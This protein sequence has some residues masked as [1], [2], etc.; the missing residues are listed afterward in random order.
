MSSELP[1]R[2]FL[3]YLTQVKEELAKRMYLSEVCCLSVYRILPPISQQC[4][5]MMIFDSNL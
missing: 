4:I 2:P 1:D 3:A 5:A